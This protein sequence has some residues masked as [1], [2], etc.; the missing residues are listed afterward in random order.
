[1]K[2]LFFLTMALFVFASCSKDELP[3]GDRP[4]GQT[5]QN[6]PC[7]YGI[8]T[9]ENAASAT[10]GVADQS[11]IWSK[12]FAENLTVKFL[13]GSATYRDFVKQ[14][15]KEWE[16][17][18]GVRF[19]FVSDTKDAMIRVGWDF[20]PGMRSSWALTGTDH[21]AVFNNQTEPTV[22]FAEWPRASDE[23]KRSDVLRAFGQALGLELEFRHPSFH[24]TWITDKTTGEIDLAKIRDYWEREL[25]GY[26]SWEE[27]KKM[28]YDPLVDQTA[29][30]SKTPT[31]DPK[32][33]MNWPF[34]QKLAN[35][36]PP[37]EYDTDYNTE[38]SAQDKEFIKGLYGDSFGGVP[39]KY[40]KL[41]EFDYAGLNFEMELTTTKDLVVIWD[42]EGKDATPI[43][44]PSGKT[45]YTATI[46]KTF[47]EAKTR[48][49]IIAEI[50]EEGQTSIRNSSA[51]TKVDIK[52]ANE[53]SNFD[54]WENNIA[55]E[56]LRIMGGEKFKGQA[57]VFNNL[58]KL[59]EVYLIQTGDS[60][61]I[62]Y[63]CP[64]L[65]IFSTSDGIWKPGKINNLPPAPIWPYFPEKK[66]SLKR[67]DIRICPLLKKISL[68]NTMI[69]TCNF[70]GL[71]Q[72][73]YIYL[74][75]TNKYLVDGLESPLKNSLSTIPDRSNLIAGKIYLRSINEA[76]TPRYQ[77]F[78]IIQSYYDEIAKITG[79]RNWNVYY[80]PSYEI[81]PE[82]VLYN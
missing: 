58:V 73:D 59:K 65:E 5:V 13:N 31:R 48:R 57:F 53:A 32:S 45:Y 80:E 36:L 11:K 18:A 22:H 24:P 60:E 46:D 52:T 51:L 56:Y 20:V 49:V 76:I 4:Q 55:L 68:E 42:L 2:K 29:F 39:K 69:T 54:I 78:L 33:V 62:L 9:L 50:L 23:R 67:L 3:D 14:T 35:N 47:T 34:F 75:S 64:K 30:I 40:L 82:N 37:I 27:L 66:A 77:T 71:S 8:A 1:M 38:L 10:R 6:V 61:A 7:I 41:M 26:I 43:E 81:Y 25:A 17:A 74:S 15:V 44:L 16:K 72:L 70:T 12:P 28:V 79:E 19:T 63:R 21:M